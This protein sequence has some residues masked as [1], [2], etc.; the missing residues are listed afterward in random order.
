MSGIDAATHRRRSRLL[1]LATLVAPP[2]VLLGC[3]SPTSPPAPPGGGSQIVLDEAS[4]VATVEPVLVAH[5]CDAGG[6]CHG[7]GIRGTFALSPQGSKDTHYDFVQAS[8]QVWPAPRDSSPILRQPLA[9]AAGGLPHPVKAFTT[10]ADSGYIA[11][12]TWVLNGVVQ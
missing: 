9:V 7:G 11:I 12:H 10:T 4:F 1:A 2:L 3:T 6:D 5:G 8:M